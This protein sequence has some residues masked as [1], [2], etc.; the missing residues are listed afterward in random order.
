MSN[1]V[2]EFLA[3]VD[4]LVGRAGD[5]FVQWELDWVERVKGRVG[6]YGSVADWQT[7]KLN[8]LEARYTDEYV[9]ESQNFR[10]NMTSEQR[11][12][13]RLACN[14]YRKQ[15]YY[16]GITGTVPESF[17]S[18]DDNDYIPSFNNYNRLTDNKYF[19]KILAAVRSEPKFET[20]QLVQFRASS[21]LPQRNPLAQP[22]N[23][24]WTPGFGFS[25]LAGMYAVVLQVAP[26]APR[27]AARGT[28]PYKVLVR[29]KATPVFAEERF[30]KKAKK[31][32]G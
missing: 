11:E 3:R 26:F 29:G 12:D 23:E 14:Y 20:G 15:G 22:S 1:E 6:H 30:L 9:S 28:K 18:G 27:T 16:S 2:N 5:L 8:E 25:K 13:F 31:V 19:K 21:S 4:A 32:K 10:E 17:I 24:D 7:D